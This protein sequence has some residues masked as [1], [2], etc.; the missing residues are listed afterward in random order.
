MSYR[1]L[2]RI[3]HAL[4]LVTGLTLIAAKTVEYGGGRVFGAVV[5]SVA[6]WVS[7]W[8][9]IAC[10]LFALLQCD[11]VVVCSIVFVE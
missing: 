2:S 10:A 5:G 11:F 8:P 9:L 6:R 7:V 3:V 1:I 4:A